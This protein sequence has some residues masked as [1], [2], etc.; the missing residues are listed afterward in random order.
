[1]RLLVAS[2]ANAVMVALCVPSLAMVGTLETTVSC[3]ATGAS[4]STRLTWLIRRTERVVAI[5]AA[6][7][8]ESYSQYDR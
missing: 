4:G 8:R 3:E 6:T 5:A 2:R 7:G 1:M